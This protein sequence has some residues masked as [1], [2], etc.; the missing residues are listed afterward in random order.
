MDPEKPQTSSGSVNSKNENGVSRKEHIAEGAPTTPGWPN[1]GPRGVVTWLGLTGVIFGYIS[2]EMLFLMPSTIQSA[3]STEL[4]SRSYIYWIG[5]GL[6]SV[7]LI[8]WVLSGSLSDKYGRKSYL[9]SGFIVTIVGSI[10]CC[11][12]DSIWKIILGTLIEGIGSGQLGNAVA[13]VSEVVPH[14]RRPAVQGLLYICPLPFVATSY[15]VG[16]TIMKNTTWKWVYYTNIIVNVVG[17][18]LVTL[19]YLPPTRNCTV[20][21]RRPSV[22]LKAALRVD[23]VGFWLLSLFTILLCI[24]LLWGGF[25]THGWDTAAVLVPLMFGLLSLIILATWENWFVK[26]PLFPKGM[27]HNLRGYGH[28]L[29]NAA[30]ASFG[31]A[32]VDQI[33]PT[34]VKTLYATS[35]IRQGVLLLPSGFGQ[36]FGAIAC[37]LLARRIGHTQIQLSVSTFLLAL[38]VALLATMTP[39]TVTPGH[40]YSLL[41][42]TCSGYN[43]VLSIIMAQFGVADKS[44]ATAT[45][46][47]QI[48][49]SMGLA[50]IVSFYYTI[51][52]S[53]VGK[54]LVKDI[55]KAVLRLGLPMT[56]LPAFIL[57]LAAGEQAALLQVPG[58]TPQ[59]IDAGVL[60]LKHVYMHAFRIIYL[61]GMASSLIALGFA[62]CTRDVTEK[63]T[64][65]VAVD[66]SK[67]EMSLLPLKASEGEPIYE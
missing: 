4:G 10:I 45:A 38:F 16:A 49:M 25:K 55:S 34:H 32:A 7:N 47:L 5:L 31:Y 28:I 36:I 37:G 56:S 64:D 67:G 8:F 18:I 1:A 21:W 66:M 29:G 20:T 3:I 43:R 59:V 63:M 53:I 26:R 13:I 39:S 40:A 57:A 50:F 12:V 52:D 27:F 22:V 14:K 33:Y 51:I 42:A 35:D 60:A 61:L 24:A 17:L 58:I 48:S 46:A 44:I 41:A 19:F 6:R 15:I 2:M 11:T 65:E 62:L 23:W 54:D 30:F 9:I